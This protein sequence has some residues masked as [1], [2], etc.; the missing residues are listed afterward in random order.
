M[1]SGTDIVF[2]S[3]YFAVDM[4]VLTIL[5]FSVFGA[6]KK[7]KKNHFE[8][9]ACLQS[10]PFMYDTLSTSYDM[11]TK[12]VSYHTTYSD[13]YIHNLKPKTRNR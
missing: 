1:R 4:I 12:S 8:V 9:R 13:P 5:Q 2:Y 6:P 7:K 10:A 3:V 11:I